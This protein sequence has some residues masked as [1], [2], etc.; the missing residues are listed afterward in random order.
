[1]SAK[2]TPTRH[3]ISRGPDGFFWLTQGLHVESTVET[4]WGLASLQ[5]AGVWRWSPRTLALEG[6]F[7]G[8]KAGHNCWGV[9]FDDAHQASAPPHLAGIG[10]EEREAVR[11]RAQVRGEDER[12]LLVALLGLATGVFR[13][14]PLPFFVGQSMILVYFI[15]SVGYNFLSFFV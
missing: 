7:N 5:K 6:F 14:E 4:P 13:P 2:T 1:M 12:R 3:S 11:D 9:A 10:D 15:Q 8:G